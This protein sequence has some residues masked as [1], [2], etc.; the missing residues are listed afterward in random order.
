MFY[1][2]Y[3]LVGEWVNNLLRK[4]FLAGAVELV[5]ADVTHTHAR[6]QTEN[7][8]LLKTLMS[9]GRSTWVHAVF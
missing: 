5:V 7:D 1:Y 4:K 3:F 9:A 2:F 6:T 8:L